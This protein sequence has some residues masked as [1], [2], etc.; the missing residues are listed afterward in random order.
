MEFKE[1]AR[2]RSS[3]FVLNDG[4]DHS[5][6]AGS[7]SLCIRLDEF[8]HR[9]H[10]AGYPFLA[11][12]G[13]RNV[14]GHEHSPKHRRGR[15]VIWRNL[16]PICQACWDRVVG[17]DRWKAKDLH[18]F[19]T[20]NANPQCCWCNSPSHGLWWKANR[21]EV[22]CHGM[23]GFH[24]ENAVIIDLDEMRAKHREDKEVMDLIGLAKGLQ[25]ELAEYE[26]NHQ[27]EHKPAS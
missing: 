7:F 26:K 1:P 3:V 10:T 9:Q 18:H 15:S 13:V 12:I 8:P 27:Q 14:E 21:L 23:F 19:F 25:K 11:Y 17:I 20:Y 2:L 22:P 5:W 4:G 16:H 24:A 6:W